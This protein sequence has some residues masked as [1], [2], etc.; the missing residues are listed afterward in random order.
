MRPSD[1]PEIYGDNSKLVD[2]TG[3]QPE[4]ALEQTLA[5]VIADWRSRS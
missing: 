5:D 1:N 2:A 4:I 3:W